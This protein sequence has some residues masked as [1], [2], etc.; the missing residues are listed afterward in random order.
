M[1]MG[2]PLIYENVRGGGQRAVDLRSKLLEN[3]I[4]LLKW[5]CDDRMSNVVYAQ[6]LYLDSITGTGEGEPI[7]LYI[8]S[9]GGSITSGMA[10]LDVILSL[11][12]EVHTIANGLAASMGAFLLSCGD[13]RF[14]TPNAEIMIHQPLG[15]AQGQ[16]TDIE[17]SA[18]RI[19]HLRE[20]L[21][22]ILAY[23]T[24]Q[25]IETI[26]EDVERDKWFMPKE[27]LEY[28]LIDE[29]IEPKKKF[30]QL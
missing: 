16:A 12:S 26:S 8:N 24:G 10:I 29:I 9:P 1:E 22:K 5:P 14:A 7:S 2:M 27:A 3:R 4:V 20:K 17:I 18:K 13:K 19:L 21:N 11:D 30:I 23:K 6:L 28:G 25:D 15:G